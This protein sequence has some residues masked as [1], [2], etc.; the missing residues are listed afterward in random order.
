MQLAS[1]GASV[2]LVGRGMGLLAEVADEIGAA[3]GRSKAVAADVS[4]DSDV[5]RLAAEAGPVDILINNA[6]A[7]ERYAPVAMADIASWKRFS[8]ST[9]S[10]P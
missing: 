10:A 9:C 1:E 8:T 3:G 2:I 4:S 5:A 6:A 7:E